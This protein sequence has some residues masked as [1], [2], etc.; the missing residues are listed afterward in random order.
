[1]RNCSGS[2]QSPKKFSNSTTTT[3]D[4]Y[5]LYRRRDVVADMKLDNRWVVPYNQ[6]LLLKYKLLLTLT[7]KFAAH[8]VQLSTSI[9]MCINAIIEP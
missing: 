7:L 5:P 3:K 1:M 6:Y 9:S 4:G 2:K 8:L